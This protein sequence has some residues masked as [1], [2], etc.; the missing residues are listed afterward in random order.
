ML[1]INKPSIGLK[2]RLVAV[3][4]FGIALFTSVA[5]TNIAVLGM[6]LMAPIAWYSFF[7]NHQS[8]ELDAKFFLGLVFA[9][10]V[11]DVVSNVHSGFGIGPSLGALLHDLRTFG[12]VILL[13]TIFTNSDVARFAYWAVCGSALA[14]ATT[15]L[16]LTAVGVV[17]QG[18]YFTTGVM[19]MS[20]MSH[21]YGQ[22]LVGMVFVFAQMWLSRPQ[23]SWRVVLPA[24]L[25]LA[26]LFF[27]SERRT[28]WLLLVAGF[29][30]W[31]FLN[32]KRLFAG[33]YKWGLLFVA[34]SIVIFVAGSDVVHRRMATA[35]WEFNQYVLM[36]PQERAGVTGSVSIRMQFVSSMVELIKH[37]NWWIGVG[38][39]G[40]TDAFHSAAERLGVTPEA[41]AV[42]NWSNPHNEYLYMLATKGVV[43][44]MLYLAIFLQASRMAWYKTDEV[45]RVGMLMYVF[46]F[47]FSITTN[48]MAIDMEEG[49]FM[50]IMLLIFLAPK[51][52]ALA[53]ARHPSR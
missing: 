44:L 9:L 7:K 5:L 52:L 51:D 11:W 22:A 33:K 8:L 28:G 43:G 31:G 2:A 18:E 29:L 14:L 41:A 3:A 26:S 20:H 32:I 27:A 40:F 12:F 47:M 4:V 25:L 45:Q 42:Y 38:S 39:L 36:T 13:W 34:V 23:C 19:N 6:L 48:S 30:V 24:V 53:Q 1:T 49:H 17:S 16:L 46:L 21:L 35:M 37:G 10:C 15:N 50:M